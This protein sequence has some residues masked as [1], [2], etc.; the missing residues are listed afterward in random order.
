MA[1]RISGASTSFFILTTMS[2][3][4]A[5]AMAFGPYLDNN[6]QASS[7]LSGV[8]YSKSGRYTFFLLYI[9]FFYIINTNNFNALSIT[10]LP[11][12]ALQPIHYFY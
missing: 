10:P 8:K 2:V 1:T 11:I 5:I 4:P 3:P 9:D 6:W 12:H 7:T